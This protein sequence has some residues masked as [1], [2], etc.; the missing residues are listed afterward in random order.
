MELDREKK[1]NEA[2]ETIIQQK[3]GY[4]VACQV[5]GKMKK[6]QDSKAE[7]IEKLLHSFPNLRVAYI[8][9]VSRTCSPRSGVVVVGALS[10][11]S[12]C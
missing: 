6:N 5:Y 8:D 7:D 4:V 10:Q 11:L 12:S 9:E 2:N 3:F 1:G